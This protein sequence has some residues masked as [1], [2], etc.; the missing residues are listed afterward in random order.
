MSTDITLALPITPKQIGK[1]AVKT[2]D[3]R[4]VHKLL[5]IQ[6]PF[7][8]WVQ[9]QF[10]KYGFQQGINFVILQNTNGVIAASGSKPHSR[11]EYH[12]T[13]NAAISICYTE[14]VNNGNPDAQGLLGYL[15]YWC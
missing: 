8:G 14:R 7:A 13:L 6:S 1:K 9:Q 11:K 3:L 12:V 2:V 5:K 10:K 4:K 15:T